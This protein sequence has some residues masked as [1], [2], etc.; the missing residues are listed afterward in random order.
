MI[1][2]E[3]T[4]I[5]VVWII[6]ISPIERGWEREIK[7]EFRIIIKDISSKISESSLLKY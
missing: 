1:R 3:K 2:P 7:I 4:A 5:I 6:S